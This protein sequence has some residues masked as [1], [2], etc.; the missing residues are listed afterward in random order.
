VIPANTRASLVASVCAL[1]LGLSAGAAL[2]DDGPPCGGLKMAEGIIEF[3]AVQPL[4]AV[5]SEAMDRCL[6]AVAEEIARR[7]AIRSVTVAARTT[8]GVAAHKDALEAGKYVAA[9]LVALGI[10]D[11]RV[12]TIVPRAAAGEPDSIR[13]AYIE[14]RVFVPVGQIHAISGRAWGGTELGALDPIAPGA[15]LI[16]EQY[17]ET[18]QGSVALIQLTDGSRLRLSENTVV[19]LG[20]VTF[21]ESHGRNVQ[22]ELLRGHGTVTARD[23]SGPFRLVTGNAVAGV[24]GTGFRIAVP[25]ANLTRIETVDGSV[26]F[27]GNRHTV[28]VARG[29]GSRVDHSGHPENPRPL[30]IAPRLRSHMMGNARVGDVLTWDDVPQAHSYL[31]EFSHNAQFTRTYWSTT[32]TEPRALLSETLTPGKWFWR[33]TAVDRDGFHG[34]SSRHYAFTV[35]A[36][37]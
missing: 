25:E 1:A 33:V 4:D 19:R 18:G 2:A 3:G 24:R 15:V 13:L 23:V 37:P 9:R 21:S 6:R 22:V 20:T 10:P 31:V 5:R 32:T 34:F 36:G 7:P 35:L 27:A 17:V 8:G 28:F 16:P 26:R 14:R 30:L 12:A 29:E 11:N